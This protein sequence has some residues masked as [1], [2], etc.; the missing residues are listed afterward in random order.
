MKEL[1]R[2]LNVLA[3][4]NLI[5]RLAI[6]RLIEGSKIFAEGNTAESLERRRDYARTHQ[7]L[8]DEIQAHVTEVRRE[9]GSGGL[10]SFQVRHKFELWDVRMPGETVA[11]LHY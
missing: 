2:W 6:Y 8:R 5:S 10:E 11:E 3:T 7:A 1:Q 9:I 4:E